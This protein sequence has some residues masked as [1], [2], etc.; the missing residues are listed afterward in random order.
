LDVVQQEYKHNIHASLLALAF[1]LNFT[2]IS[3]SAQM[4]KIMKRLTGSQGAGIGVGGTFFIL[5]L[6]IGIYFLMQRTKKARFLKKAA[7]STSATPS[8]TANSTPTTT[9]NTPTDPRYAAASALEM[10]TAEGNTHQLHTAENAHE[11]DAPDKLHEMGDLAPEYGAE[12]GIHVEGDVGADVGA[13]DHEQ[14]SIYPQGDHGKYEDEKRAGMHG[15]GGVVP[16]EKQTGSTEPVAELEGDVAFPD[17][18]AQ[19]EG[20]RQVVG[21]E[22]GKEGVGEGFVLA[23]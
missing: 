8:P 13:V 21:E 3:Q 14:S 22:A 11:L 10:A 12:G 18:R 20:E 6:G 16:D 7:T 17:R 2:Y 15:E 23:D 1:P 4:A 9:T 19:G 5:F